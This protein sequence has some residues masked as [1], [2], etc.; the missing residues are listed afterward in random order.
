MSILDLINQNTQKDGGAK[1]SKKSK[2][3]KTNRKVTK[4]SK[5]KKKSPRKGTKRAT[6]KPCRRYT[7]KACPTRS[8]CSIT[9][10]RK[11]GRRSC[12]AKRL[13]R[14]QRF[15]KTAKGRKMSM[16]VYKYKG[17][18]RVKS[19]HRSRKTPIRYDYPNA[20][21]THTYKKATATRHKKRTH[22]GRTYEAKV[23]KTH[24]ANYNT[25]LGNTGLRGLFN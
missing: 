18:R 23:G 8:V 6:G 10:S 16:K 1:R 15:V 11:T 24:E 12:V 13:T 17:S 22:K 21:K 5:G 25:A 20:I 19:T 3:K 9:K 4:K 14:K 7:L 2:S